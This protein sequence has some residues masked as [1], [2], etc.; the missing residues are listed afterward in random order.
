MRWTV[1]SLLFSG[2]LALCILYAPHFLEAQVG[3]VD[4]SCIVNDDGG[5]DSCNANLDDAATGESAE[6]PEKTKLQR[7][8]VDG[9]DLGEPQRILP[10]EENKINVKALKGHIEQAR[11]Y[12][13]SAE[14][15]NKRLGPQVMEHCRNQHEHCAYWSLLGE[16]EANPGYMK[17]NC[18]PVCRSCDYLTLE[19]RCDMTDRSEDTWAPGDLE[20][21]FRRLTNEPFLSKHT[22]QILSSP[23]TKDGGPWVITLENV[24]SEEEAQILI[25][26][27]EKEGYKRSLDAGPVKFDGTI[28]D[29]ESKDRTSFN[30]WCNSDE[31]Q[32]NDTVQDVTNKISGLVGIPSVNSEH[33]QMLRY[34]VGQL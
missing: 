29:V 5:S 31:C 6:T 24:F 20:G 3:D 16:C 1:S 9:S 30:A 28:T 19:G 26:V 13:Q 10:G 32:R 23:E 34:E 12:M 25:G 7:P 4:G 15:T 27:G 2:W 11:A 8:P 33:F 18:A 14:L 21:M 22:V 17:L